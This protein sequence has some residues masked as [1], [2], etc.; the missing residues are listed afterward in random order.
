VASDFD[1]GVFM[2]CRLAFLPMLLLSSAVALAAD[3]EPA[4]DAVATGFSWTG[5]YVGLAAGVSHHEAEW[6]DQADDWINGSET[7]DSTSA[8]V[9]GYAGYNMELG[10]I[11]LGVEA[12]ISAAFNEDSGTGP[13][14]DEIYTNE[15]DWIG[16]VRGRI[17]VP[18]D[19]MLIYAT[20]GWAFAGVTNEST[21]DDYPNEDFEDTDDTVTGYVLGG[22][23]EYALSDNVLLRVEG[24][25]Y[26]FED[27]TY[28]QDQDPD[29]E[30]T[31]DN[32]VIV[33]KFGISFKF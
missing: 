13:K 4:P 16:S 25:S 22:G 27:S 9:G 10:A 30:M 17:G 19:R 8:L 14:Y 20:G 33:G 7:F 24:L 15:L 26:D 32:S 11:V 23:V 31:I 21:S 28:A 6:T 29:D 12:D 18:I 5:A 2:V 3:L 1:L